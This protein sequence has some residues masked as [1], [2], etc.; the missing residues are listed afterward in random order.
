MKN[1][2]PALILVLYMIY[3]SGCSNQ[4][5]E[6]GGNIPVLDLEKEYP[7]KDWLVSEHA[8]LEYIRMETSDEVLIDGLASLHLSVTDQHITTC[9]SR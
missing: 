6:E 8:D 9:N 7:E 2:I 1:I 3:G 4:S 5:N